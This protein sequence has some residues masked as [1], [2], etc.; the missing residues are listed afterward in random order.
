[1]IPEELVIFNS[2]AFK[3][4]LQGEFVN[5]I[6][7]YINDQIEE[8]ETVEVAKVYQSCLKN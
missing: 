4:S 6:E 1:M 8:M 3:N 2:L 5:Q 7:S